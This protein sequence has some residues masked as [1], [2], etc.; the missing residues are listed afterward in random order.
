[1]YNNIADYC[2]KYVQAT[3]WHPHAVSSSVLWHPHI[4]SNPR[5]SYEDLDSEQNY[6][7][8]N[9]FNI[10]HYNSLMLMFYRK[11]C[12]ITHYAIISSSPFLSKWTLPSV[13][14]KNSISEIRGVQVPLQVFCSDHLIKNQHSRSRI[15]ILTK[16][17]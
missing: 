3:S 6:L 13:M 11:R 15:Y 2:G 12:K 4:I 5:I 1:M 10:F 9:N 7:R 14:W 8:W 17:F 16:S